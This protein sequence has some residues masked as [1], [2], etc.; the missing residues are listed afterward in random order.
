[1]IFQRFT[2]LD[3]PPPRRHGPAGYVDYRT[4]K[5]W[6]RDEFNFRC[7]Y[8]LVRERWSPLGADS[9][10]VDHVIPRS[11]T[12]ELVG[13]YEN[14]VYAC[15]ACNSAKREQLLQLDPC[16][17][18]YGIHLR[19]REDGVMENLTP[20]GAT[21]IQRLNLNRA[22]LLH[23]RR[24]MLWMPARVK[25]DPN[26]DLAVYLRSLMAF[27]I[28]LPNLAS[29]HPPGGNTRPEGLQTCYFAQRARGELPATY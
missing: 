3:Q 16:R 7:V 17:E 12:A 9:F 2:Y 4:F 1:M 23:L 28:D 26:G 8:C 29:L 25:A 24:Q 14:L 22:D 21:V 18:R 19:M 5:P 20:N 13:A 11:H 15:S 10:G 27:P 6:L